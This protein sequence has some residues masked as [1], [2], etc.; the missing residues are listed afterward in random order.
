MTQAAGGEVVSAGPSSGEGYVWAGK[1]TTNIPH[2]QPGA[3]AEL[4]LQVDV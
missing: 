2:L 4:P 1:T 3:T